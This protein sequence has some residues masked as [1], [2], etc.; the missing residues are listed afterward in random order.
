MDV[1]TSGY[2]LVQAEGG[3]RDDLVTGVQ[4]CALPICLALARAPWARARARPRGPGFVTESQ[5]R[6]PKK[7]SKRKRA[8]RPYMA[9]IGRASCRERVKISVFA[10]SL[11]K[12]SETLTS[13]AEITNEATI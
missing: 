2:F 5:A 9:E 11:K 1:R 7:T 10:V 8:G 13:R 6:R 4:T 3:I 12:K